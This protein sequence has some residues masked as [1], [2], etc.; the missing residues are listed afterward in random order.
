MKCMYATMV[1]FGDHG[2][3]KKQLEMCNRNTYGAHECEMYA[4]VW[5]W[6]VT[7]IHDVKCVIQ[8]F[9]MELEKQ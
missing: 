1:F 7:Y 6:F 4:M 2:M 3:S 8:R 5:L 9:Q